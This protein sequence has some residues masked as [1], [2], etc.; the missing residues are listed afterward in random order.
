MPLA[1]PRPCTHPGCGVLVRD[2]SGRCAA[3]PRPVWAKREDSPK[4]ITGRALQARRLRLWTAN[5][6]CAACGR[7]T[8]YPRGFELDHVVR[9]ADGGE[10]VDGNCQVLCVDRDAQGE[11]VGCHAD[12]TA[13]EKRQDG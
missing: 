10:D 3:H 9:L 1:A 2:G 11:K 5:P 4:R 8:S 6:L 12:K 7:L 13:R